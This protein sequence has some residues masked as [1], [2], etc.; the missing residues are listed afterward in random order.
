MGLKVLMLSFCLNR[1]LLYIFFLRDNQIMRMMIFQSL[2]QA[3]L[4]KTIQVLQ[5]GVKGTYDIL[6]TVPDI[7]CK[8]DSWELDH[9]T[10]FILQF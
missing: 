6:I 2:T 8:G 7:T 1:V 9:Y 4:E 3:Y 5:T 10:R